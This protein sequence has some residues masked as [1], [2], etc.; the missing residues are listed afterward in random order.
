MSE[1]VHSILEW[2]SGGS[3]LDALAKI[4]GAI[5]SVVFVHLHRRYVAILGANRRRPD[6]RKAYDRLRS[7]LAEGNLAARLYAEQLTLDWID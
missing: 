2:V 4:A 7:S 6:E 3:A 1:V 5:C